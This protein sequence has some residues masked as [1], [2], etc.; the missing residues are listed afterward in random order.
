VTKGNATPSKRKIPK[1]S[2]LPVPPG[3]VKL[4]PVATPIRKKTMEA[5]QKT[6][7]QLEAEKE[8]EKKKK[9]KVVLRPP[10]YSHPNQR[11]AIAQNRNKVS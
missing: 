10:Q 5:P 3:K 7:T 4:D 2:A 11:E 1:P 9:N 6:Q 8:D